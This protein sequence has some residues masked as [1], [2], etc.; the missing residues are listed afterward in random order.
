MLNNIDDSSDFSPVIIQYGRTVENELKEIFGNIDNSKK[1][2]LGIMQGSLEKFKNGNS[3]LPKC[4]PSEFAQLQVELANR[5]NSPS[6][7]KI[8]LIDDIRDIRNSSGHSGA[9]KTKQNAINYIE[10]VNEFLDKWISEKK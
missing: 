10:K 2:M 1:W 7:L 3:T 9:L 4:S 8:N 5:F 6:D